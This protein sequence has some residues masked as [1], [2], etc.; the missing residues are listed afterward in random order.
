MWQ[1][2]A[3]LHLLFRKIVNGAWNYRGRKCEIHFMPWLRSSD[4]HTA[5]GRE[6]RCSVLH[7]IF[8]LMPSFPWQLPAKLFP[9]PI[10]LPEPT[11][12]LNIQVQLKLSFRFLTTGTTV[13]ISP[14]WQFLL[15]GAT[16]FRKQYHFDISTW[17]LPA[18][19]YSSPSLWISL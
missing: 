16:Q 13:I 6:S 12:T 2:Y 1:A 15:I 14:D 19:S 18:G 5:L 10:P 8:L 9:L 17:Q 7:Q 4:S 3:N 11:G